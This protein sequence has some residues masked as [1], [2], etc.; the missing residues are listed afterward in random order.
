MREHLIT[1]S[2]PSNLTVIA[3]RPSGLGGAIS[4]VMDSSAC[5]LPGLL[6]LG[7][8]QGASVLQ[9]KEV[10]GWGPR[11]ETDMDHARRIMNTCW[12]MC[13]SSLSK[14]PAQTTEFDIYTPPKMIKDFAVLPSLDGIRDEDDADWRQDLIGDTVNEHTPMSP[15]IAESLL[16]L[17]RITSD[18][19]Y[20]QWGWELFEAH[21][22]FASYRAVR[23]Y[24]SPS[25]AS[26]AGGF[27]SDLMDNFLP[28]STF[29]CRLTVIV[30]LKAV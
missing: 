3:E 27:Q 22:K 24:E 13:K 1:Y 5:V 9:A 28:V 25:S 15:Q 21:M 14:L 12:A 6:A 11:Q 26:N 30:A 8:T 4:S 29:V 18:E 19:K 2:S 23:S 7:V 16:Y 10:K 17:W 20:R